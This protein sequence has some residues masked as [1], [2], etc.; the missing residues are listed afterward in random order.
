M[1]PYPSGRLHM[2]HI[3]NYS[4]GDALARYKHMRGWN[5]L[6]PM[7][8]DAY[9]LPG[10]ERGDQEPGPS[11]EMDARQ[12]RLHEAAIPAVRLRVRLVERTCHVRSGILPV[13]PVVLFE[14]AGARSGLP[15]NEPRQLVSGLPDG[16]RERAGGGRL[17]LATRHDA[18]RAQGTGT[19]VLPHHGLRRRAARRHEAARQLAGAG[20]RDA[21]ELDRQV[22][23]CADRLP[24]RGPRRGDYR[25]HD[26]PGHDLRRDGAAALTRPS[27]DRAPAR[28]HRGRG[29]HSGRGPQTPGPQGGGAARADRQG[30]HLSRAVRRQP[31]HGRT[32][33]DLGGEFRADGVRHGRRHGGSRTRPTRFR[34]R[35]EVPPAG[36][37]GG[38]ELGTRP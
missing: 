15:E 25:L 30:R 6:H 18:G 4:I 2:G 19:M 24:R 23:R 1:L 31:L 27:V 8:W 29:Q 10:R 11:P 37:G 34:V 3:R 12:H 14:D 20:A 38:P 7:G 5:V 9:G 17:L 22:G 36:A 35:R 32:G 28:R 21:A 13:E 26:P 16:A 33:P